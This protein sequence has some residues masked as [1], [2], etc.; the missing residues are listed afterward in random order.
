VDPNKESGSVQLD[1]TEVEFGGNTPSGGK[2]A[3]PWNLHGWSAD[4]AHDGPSN[5]KVKPFSYYDEDSDDN[6][7]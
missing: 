7:E 3:V 4:P 6:D 1:G 2:F 5:F